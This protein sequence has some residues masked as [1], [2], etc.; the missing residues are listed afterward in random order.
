MIVTVFGCSFRL[1]Q[2]TG[3]GLDDSGSACTQPVIKGEAC[4][5]FLQGNLTA[6]TNSMCSASSPTV[7]RGT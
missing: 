5:L 1:A 4:V 3:Y 7:N 6:W 2:P